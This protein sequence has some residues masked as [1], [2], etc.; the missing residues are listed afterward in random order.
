MKFAIVCLLAS[1]A[2]AEQIVEEPTELR[3]GG[4]GTSKVDPTRYYTTDPASSMADA[5]SG[6]A[7]MDNMNSGMDSAIGDAEAKLDAM[8]GTYTP[9]AIGVDKAAVKD[10]MEAER[11]FWQNDAKKFEQ[12]GQS[13]M[14]EALQKTEIRMA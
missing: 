13:A 10:V 8:P 11:N 5:T 4:G 6:T 9:P 14:A 12:A 7:A 2:A 1:C 3:R